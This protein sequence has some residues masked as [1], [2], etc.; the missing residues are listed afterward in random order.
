MRLKIIRILIIIGFIV[1]TLELVYVQMIRGPYYYR[2]S[3]NN[4]IRVV[5]LEGYRGRIYD[6]NGL[7]LADNRVSYDVMV[8]PQDIEDRDELF[9][10]LS[11]ALSLDS[12]K[13]HR[14]YL[15]KKFAPFAPVTLVEDVDKKKAIVLEENRFRFPSLI[16]H[17]SFKRNYPHDKSA[18]HV[19]G[20]V[21]KINRAKYERFQEY[22]YSQQSIIGYSGVEEY[23]DSYLKGEQ[24]GVQVEVNS[25]GKQVRILSIKDPAQGQDITLTIDK[26]LQVMSE[27]LLGQKR[28]A[29]IM[30]D[31]DSGEILTMASAPSYDPNV[32][33]DKTKSKQVTAL[34]KSKRAP[35]LNR[36]IRGAYPPG[37]VFKIPM[38]LAGLDTR[39]ITKDS[40]VESKGYFDLGGI[41]FGCTA[42]PGK[43]NLN[44]SLAHSCNVYYYKL[45]L[46]LGPELINEYA[47]RFGL[48]ELTHI[49]LPHEKKGQMPSPRQRMLKKR[50]RWYKGHT[51]NY[52]I[53]QGDALTTPMQL[54]HMMAIVANDGKVVQPHLLRAV[55]GEKVE[56]VK[57]SKN[58]KIKKKHFESVQKGMRSAVTDY[59]GTAH[60]L[61][62]KDLYVAGK[63]GT[64][65]S[66]PG[67]EHHAWFVGFVN[68]DKM[69][70][71]FCIFLE[72]GGS[73]HNATLLARQLLMEMKETKFL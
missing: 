30:M 35:L 51:L 13:L 39:K 46:R 44:E 3:T 71:A 45:G 2:L 52:S 73:S 24:G 72:H 28:G 31:L 56:P 50:Q 42:P 66:S 19:L 17:K 25:R 1:I 34:F 16:I 54:V 70:F 11:D 65:Q 67:K 9:N 41:R 5:P 38:A 12:K 23:Y 48:G 40:L 4:R 68:N 32:F 20:Y 61:D 43:Y 33:L 26:S 62:L 49:D 29:I 36:T 60:F 15:N 7:L 37:S 21:G 27:K 55:S 63:T 18:A 6:R 57:Y 53:G 14:S 22:G 47:K 8:T 58:L 10:F 69:N 64:A 59:A